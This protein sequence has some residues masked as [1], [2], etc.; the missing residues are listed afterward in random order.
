LDV[1]SDVE[2]EMFSNDDDE[3][4]GVRFDDSED[5]RTTAL[6]DGF[7]MVEVEA[8]TNGT[9]RVTISNKSVRIRMCGSKSP[10]K[11]TSGM[12]NVLAPFLF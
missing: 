7:E 9:N 8:P 3:V 6:E 10:K 4:K 5:E 1:G 11:K 12:V 2:V